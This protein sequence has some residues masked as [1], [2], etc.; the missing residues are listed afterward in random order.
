MRAARLHKYREPLIVEDV[1]KPPIVDGGGILL[2]VAGAGVCHSD[3]H[4][5]AG[6]LGSPL[7]L[8]YI[9]GHE[10]SGRIAEIGPEVSTFRKGDSVLVYGGWGCGHC[11]T[12]I[13]GDE[14]LCSEPKWPGLGPAYQG[15]FAEF[16]YVPSERYL[17]SV[18]GDST[19]LAPLSDA[20]LT[21]Y[22]A[23]K[24]VRSRLLPSS[25]SLVV[26]LGGLGIFGLQFLKTLTGCKVIAVD[27]D[28]RKLGPAEELGA[29]WVIDSGKT[30]P[31]D[32]IMKATHGK[33]VEVVLDFVCSEDTSALALKSLAKQGMYVAVGLAGGIISEPSRN[34]IRGE[35]ILTGSHWGNH[36]ELSEVYDLYREG[37]IKLNIERYDLQKINE[38]FMQLKNGEIRGRAIM[39]P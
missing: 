13:R 21:P 34:L 11:D 31:L 10:V 4:V 24:K 3:L 39:I 27:N 16:M 30:N 35:S 32:S 19:D 26:G 36:A 25:C 22:R 7:P 14:Q 6:D 28:G 8:P 23:V 29:E 17:L 18:E 15:G 1:P 9:L 2:A 5:M 33:G 12:C 37:R 38:V 20:A